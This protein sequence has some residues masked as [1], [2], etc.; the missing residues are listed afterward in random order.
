MR[1]NTRIFSVS[2]ALGIVAWVLDG[3]METFVFRKGTLLEMLITNVSPEE[4]FH[5]VLVLIL[6]LAFG[7]IISKV[8][9]EKQTAER[10]ASRRAL[11]E[12][13]EWFRGLAEDL[14]EPVFEVD[15]TARVTYVNRRA[16]ELWEYS[17]ED[18]D[19]GLSGFD[20]LAPECRENAQETFR[21][22]ME[23][24]DPGIVEYTA[25]RKDGSTFPILFHASLIRIEGKPVGIR[26]IIVDMTSQKEAEEV[27]R[28][29]ERRFR[30]IVESSPM[31]VFLYQLQSDGR[32]V[33]AAANP[34]ANEIL[35]VNASGF[36]GKTIEEAFPPLA[37]TEIPSRY[38]AA[39]AHGH[40]WHTDD[41]GYDHGGAEG[42]YEVS[43]FQTAPNEVAVMFADVT[44]RTRAEEAIKTSEERLRLAA[45]SG[46]IGVWEY[47]LVTD[48]LEWDD[49]M[50]EL[51]GTPLFY[52]EDGIQRW[53]DFVHPDDLERA[54]EEFMT[55]LAEGQGS[56]NTQFR[57]VRGDS[58]ETR[59]IRG[60]AGLFK[61]E[62]GTPIRAVGTNWDI[63]ES[64][65]TEEALW[66]SEMRFRSVIEQLS[67]AT[68]ILYNGRFDLVN[69]RFSELTGVSADEAAAPDFDFWE[70]VAPSSV[71]VIRE[72]Q[73]Q[74]ER[75]EEIPGIYE[76]EI[77]RRGGSVIQVEASVTEIDYGEGK[78]IL[79]LL[80]DIT[81]QKNLKEQLLLA[82]KMESIGRL[83]GGVAHDL[84]NLL[85]PIIGYGELVLNGFSPE[86]K[87]RADTQ[88]ILNAALR[89]RDLVRQLLAFGRQQPMV[90]ETVDLNEMVGR[91][92]SLL[93]RTIRTDIE[94]RF[95]PGPTEP[96]IRGDRGQ[97][98]QVI[99]NLAV[100]AQDAMP[101]GGLLTIETSEVELDEG[102]A[103]G[104]SGVTA[105]PYA[106][107]SV[108]DSGAG[109]DAETR[110]KIF[111]PFFTTKGR[112][113]GTGLGLSTVYGIVK[114]HEGNIWVYSEPGQG[115]A[116]KCYFPIA[117]ESG[118]TQTA[119]RDEVVELG[120][121]ETI[122]VVED[123]TIVRNLATRVLRERGYSV[124]DAENGVACL[125]FLRDHDG[126]LDLLLTDVVMP[127][128]NGR[129][130]YGEVKGL[131]PQA[132]VL[133]MSG[134]P[135]H[136]VTN[137][138][139]L[140]EGIPFIQKP[141]FVQ[142]LATRVRKVLGEG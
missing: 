107:L 21:R 38:R 83:S 12:S 56:Y 132:K 47:D 35:G 98:E 68:Y 75:G 61:D 45:L 55:F 64:V 104:H 1:F 42:A 106:L 63:T 62:R 36:I 79:G 70:L 58:G 13:E 28:E 126:P 86:D 22:R 60:L 8:L 53:R 34:A 23:G 40:S 101:E 121:T 76:F 125:E 30:N 9:R 85:I 44:E 89:A 90:L 37:D 50:Y 15:L 128:L 116:F 48:H 113:E 100:N 123:E 49:L 134:Y 108:S 136:I 102:Y 138:G 109:M 51:H 39:A 73:E 82:Q 4:V 65:R 118:V 41:L 69:Q 6:L 133:Y 52:P 141:F 135:E 20:M 19:R 95:H 127:G 120:G 99:M 32:L 81:E 97:L 59:Y 88:E 54:E 137:R 5:R 139:V 80:R 92:Q 84:N 77:K 71:P 130:L 24:E 7:L 87:R 142:A 3:L 74:R 115:T 112:E 66:D 96:S 25:L 2:L 103:T 114:Q 43:A 72:R 18:L 131:F 110:D 111:E 26:G 11:E 117:E 140:A 94:I 46:R 33:F 67:D 29:S 124:F 17:Q 27:L 105:G 14:P 31:G 129:E 10:E 16:F 119:H 93:R 122:M 78:A 91:F 57:I